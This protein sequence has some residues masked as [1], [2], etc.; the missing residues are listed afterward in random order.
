MNCQRPPFWD[1]ERGAGARSKN[2]GAGNAL[3]VVS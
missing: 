3:I 1:E 2:S